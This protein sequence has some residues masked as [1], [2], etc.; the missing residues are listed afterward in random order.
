MNIFVKFPRRVQDEILEDYDRIRNEQLA[1]EGIAQF[2][3]LL[4]EKSC[5]VHEPKWTRITTPLN[6]FVEGTPP[7]VLERAEDEYANLGRLEEAFL[8]YE[9][10]E[11]AGT[12]FGWIYHNTPWTT[13]AE[14]ETALAIEGVE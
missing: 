1:A 6:M 10:P 2:E 9:C 5:L 13:A 4:A 3:A 12:T 14:V 7:E 11:C 8:V